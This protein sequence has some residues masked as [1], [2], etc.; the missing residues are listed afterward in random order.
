MVPSAPGF[1]EEFLQEDNWAQISR[2]FGIPQKTENEVWSDDQE[3][4]PSAG[5]NTEVVFKPCRSWQFVLWCGYSRWS[6]VPFFTI[7]ISVRVMKN[8]FKVRCL[9]LLPPTFLILRFFNSIKQPYY[10]KSLTSPRNLALA[11]S[12]KSRVVLS[13]KVTA[14]PLLWSWGVVFC[15]WLG[16]VAGRK[17]FEPGISLPVCLFKTNLKLHNTPVISTTDSLRPLVL[18]FFLICSFDKSWAWNFIMRLKLAFQIDGKS[19]LWSPCLRML[20]WGLRLKTATLK[21]FFWLL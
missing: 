17:L 20:T 14:I 3:A 6:L 21:V 15:I 4:S 11:T 19:H 10:L 12:G 7:D 1:H 9:I 16:K 18:Y 8:Y 2:R 5:K 13:T